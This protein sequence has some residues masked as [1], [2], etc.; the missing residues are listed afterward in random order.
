MKDESFFAKYQVVD[1]I[2]NLFDDIVGFTF[3]IKDLDLRYVAYNDRLKEIFHIEHPEDVLGKLD[4]DFLPPAIAEDIKNDDLLIIS[5]GK[6]IENKV[7]LVTSSLMPGLVNWTI[8]TKRPLYNH[9]GEICGI[10]GITHP[11]TQGGMVGDKHEELGEAIQY[12]KANFRTKVTISDLA[13]ISNCSER[14]FLRKFKNHLNIPPSEYIKTLR[15]NEACHLLANTSKTLSE[16]SYE[17]GFSD[18]SHFTREFSRTIKLTPLA[19]R[20][21]S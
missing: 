6:P 1:S 9:Q 16:I 17:C 15:I 18:Q 12:I 14:T 11:Y 2:I 13:K 7:E 4:S 10:L 19:Y 21:Q 8:T 3:F 20:K 5:S